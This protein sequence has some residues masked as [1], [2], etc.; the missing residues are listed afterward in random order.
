[1]TSPQPEDRPPSGLANFFS[2]LG[3]VMTLGVAVLF[4]AHVVDGPIVTGLG[5]VAAT[6]GVIVI[7]R[8][9]WRQIKT[10]QRGTRRL[11]FTTIT[12]IASVASLVFLG[13][14]LPSNNRNSEVQDINGGCSKYII[15]SQDRWK[16]YGAKLMA[17]PY[18]DAKQIGG[19]PPNKLIYVDGWVH[20]E[21][22]Q[23]SN[24]IPPWNSDIWFHL[25]DGSGWVS[26]AGT[27]AVPTPP[28]P[29]GLSTNGGTPPP[30]PSKCEAALN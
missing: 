8:E 3:P 6:V 29:T 19:I 21:I 18:R 26:L 10:T 24:V 7:V 16:P 2:V 14:I 13:L 30:T 20:S 11:A 17:T 25:A 28:D 9:I 15:Y 12:A 1:M 4:A 5:V 23:P 22:A 27:R